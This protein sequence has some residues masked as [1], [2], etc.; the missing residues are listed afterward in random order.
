MNNITLEMLVRAGNTAAVLE[1]SL[2]EK[3]PEDLKKDKLAEAS[4]YGLIRK[5]EGELI[6]SDPIC[7]NLRTEPVTEYL[8]KTTLNIELLKEL[9]GIMWEGANASIEPYGQIPVFDILGV[10][11]VAEAINR[12]MNDTVLH[13]QMTL[14]IERG[15]QLVFCPF[16]IDKEH[17]EQYFPI[18]DEW[19]DLVDP[20]QIASDA[21]D[22][23]EDD[24]WDQDYSRDFIDAATEKLIELTDK[25]TVSKLLARFNELEHH[26]ELTESGK[27]DKI[28][29]S[30]REDLGEQASKALRKFENDRSPYY[31]AAETLAEAVDASVISRSMGEWLKKGKFNHIRAILRYVKQEKKRVYDDSAKNHVGFAI[32]DAIK[33]NK[34]ERLDFVLELSKDLIDRDN[35]N[36]ETV[37]RAYDLC[38]KEIRPSQELKA[39]LASDADKFDPKFLDV[40]LVRVYVEDNGYS[41]DFLDTIK[42][43]TR[44]DSSVIMANHDWLIALVDGLKKFGHDPHKL[45]REEALEIY[46]KSE[47]PELPKIWNTRFTIATE[48]YEGLILHVPKPEEAKTLEQRGL[49]LVGV[50]IDGA[51]ELKPVSEEMSK[52]ISEL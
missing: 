9:V 21:V 4:I 20:K 8:N 48:G 18:I 50:D 16:D 22:D 12:H 45:K 35:P 30:S 11:A 34:T 17:V 38:S 41:I 6:D 27:L 37:V 29:E 25:E 23:W 46:E 31:K 40:C 15:Y 26:K 52:K 39:L 7:A 3:L 13:K 51:Y 33:G 49:Y 47:L 19:R 28:D 2:D 24:L 44:Y 5:M 42:Y 1:Y 10:N 36:I 32:E 43:K 14:L